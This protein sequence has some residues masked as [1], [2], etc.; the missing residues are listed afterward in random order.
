MAD[1]DFRSAVEPE[2]LPHW[3]RVA[4]AARCARRVQPL[5]RGHWPDV[6]R[7]RIDAVERAI[8]LA[9]RSAAQGRPEDGLDEAILHAVMA[10]GAALRQVYD[11][12]N[13]T[14]PAPRDETDAAIA[15]QTAKAAENTAEAARAEAP[16]SARCALEAFGF[17]YA[18]ATD[19]GQPA[20]IRYIRR[21]FAILRCAARSKG[22]TDK[23][24]V[25]ASFLQ[26]LSNDAGPPR[27][28]WKFW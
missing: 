11:V 9:E 6:K 26:I 19:A 12:P 27:P 15:S 13:S 17:A 21:D 23:T 3:A 1:D 28:W 18:A 10:A 7:E 5:L 2:A 16:K 24:P 14:E 22:W 4:F 20:I 8:D 25:P